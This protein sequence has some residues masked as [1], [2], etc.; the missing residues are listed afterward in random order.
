MAKARTMWEAQVPRR[1]RMQHQWDT[2]Q[3]RSN[4]RSGRGANTRQQSRIEVEKVIVLADAQVSALYI[5]IIVAP[6]GSGLT[7]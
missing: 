6:D 3:R 5:K 2:H 4:S 7:N 1:V